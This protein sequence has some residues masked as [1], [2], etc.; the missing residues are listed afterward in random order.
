MV[1]RPGLYQASDNAGEL[2]PELHGRTDIKQ[3]YSGLAYARNIEPVPQGGGRLSPRSRHLGRIRNRLA[4]TQA[5]TATTDPGPHVASGAVI[6]FMSFVG[7]Q[8]VSVVTLGSMSASIPLGAIL[9]VEYNDGDWRPFAAPFGC[10]PRNANRTIARA[11]GDSVYALYLRVRLIAPPPSPVSF[12]IPSIQA[13]HETDALPVVKLR[14]FTFSLSQTYV[15]AI[16]PEIVDYYRDGSYVGSARAGISDEMVGRIESQQRLDTQLLFHQDLYPVRVFRDG[17]DNQWITDNIPFTDVPSVDLGGSYANQV[18]DVWQ[19]LLRYPTAADQPNRFGADLLF[20]ISV[21]GEDS[22]PIPTGAGPVNWSAVAADL[23]VV[24]EGMASVESGITVTEDHS[25]NGLT[26]FTVSFTGAGNLG[27]VNALS[28]QVVNSGYAATTCTHTQTGRP[29][30]EALISIAKGW[31]ATATYYQDRLLT[32]GFKAKQGA[33]LAS[34]SG[35]YFNVNT[36]ISSASGA[37]LWNIDTDGSESIHCVTKS[38]DL[39]VFTSDAEYFCSDRTLTRTSVP[40]MVNCSR[41]G[42]APGLPIVENEGSLLYVSRN[43]AL[44]YSFTFDYVAQAYIST[45]I[46]LLASHIA[47]DIVDMAIQKSSTATDGARLLMPRSDGTMTLGILL[48]NQD[49]AGFVRWETSGQVRVVCVDGKNAPHIIVQRSVGGRQEL[50]LER[51]ELGLIFDDTIEQS[52]S[53]PRN[54]ITGLDRH[55][56]AEVWAQADGYVVGPFIVAS[57]AITLGDPASHVLVGRWTP[58]LRRSLPIPSEIKDRTVLRRPKRVHTVRIDLVDTTSIAVGANSQPA[59]N[60]ALHRAGDETDIP[61]PPVSDT[62]VVT[63]LRG[64]SDFGQVDITQTRPGLLAWRGVTI[65]ART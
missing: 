61:Q 54:V 12:L 33:L 20:T 26:V 4:E 60:V 49:V 13:Q 28:A 19:I 22:R 32:A 21:N 2:K 10:S 16:M 23:I 5:M 48:R 39:V 9:Q 46:T 38:R 53:S 63:G 37:I 31:P 41:N 30:G 15:A 40:N 65:E 1:A 56:G 8:P 42:S 59:R 51:L 58:P 47:S 62:I 27:S 50:H 6:A 36:I 52:F 18:V 44:I 17:A 43:N 3:F 24:I 64:F 25:A 11:P 34:V 35:D 45:P 29:G 14:P 57:G 55:E 7:L